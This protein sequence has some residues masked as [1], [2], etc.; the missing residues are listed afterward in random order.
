M[1][2]GV[3]ARGARGL[4]HHAGIQ[5]LRGACVLAIFGYHVVNSG[6]LPMPG[7]DWLASLRWLSNGLRYGVEVF[8]MIS[9]YVIVHSLRR[10]RNVA[11]F[12][13]DRMLRIFPL[14]LPLAIAMLLGM[15]Q[16][17]RT[18]GTPT[19]ALP[20]AW[21]LLPSLLILAPVLP[22]PA[23]HPAQWSLCYELFFYGFAA[24]AWQSR[25]QP[26]WQRAGWLLPACVFVLLFPRALFFVPGVLMA[27]HEPWLRERA[28]WFRWGWLGLPAAWVAWLSTGAEDAGLSRTLFDFALAGQGWLTAIAFGGATSFFV[29]LVLFR[30]PGARPGGVLASRAMQ[31][32]GTVSFSFYLVHPIVMGVVKRLLLPAV[33]AD[34]WLSIA[35][36]VLLSFSVSCV[37]SWLTWKFLE[38]GLRRV[39]WSWPAVERPMTVV[40]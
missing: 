2:S 1:T 12:L 4:E 25:M 18:F 34:V 7:S 20:D 28:S 29:W 19:H 17:E 9:G 15:W 3:A 23:I 16:V 32:L 6:L 39:L 13:R 8:F 33:Q 36:F 30:G 14:W 22:V 21:T 24:A 35:G 27:L 26:W 37:L 38:V 5:G 31:W 10:H 11:L 40:K